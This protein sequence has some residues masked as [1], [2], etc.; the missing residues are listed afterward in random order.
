M[1]LTLKI[2]IVKD[3]SVKAMKFAPTMFVHEACAQIRE[4][5]NDSG[6]DH[7]LFQPGIEGKRPSRWLKMD[8]TLQLYDLKMNDEIDYKKKHR[9]LKVKLMDE[10]LKTLLIDD[11]LSVGE[12]IEIIGKRI[13]I[14]NHEEFSLQAEQG[15]ATSDWLNH[16]QP[17]HEQGVSDEAIVLLKKKFFV[18]D[19]NVNRDDPIQL[20]LVYVQSRDA[21]ISGSHPCTYDEAIQFGALQCQIQLGNHNT[22][23][24]KPG[25]LK[26]KE[27]MPPS[28]HKKKDAEKD[29]YKEFRKLVGMTESNSKFRYVQLCRSLKTYG[30]T[31]FQTKER[32]KGQKKPVPKLLG[33]TRDSVL[34]LDAETKEVEH[35]YPLTHL[36]RWAA[37][38]ASFTLDFGDYEDDYVSVITSDGEA[39]SQ[40]LSGYIEILMKKRKD[41]SVTV[42]EGDTDIANIESI[43]RIRGQAANTTTSS[44]L[45]GFDGAGGREGQYS[46]P[47]QSIGYRGGLGGPLSVKV[48]NIDSASAAVANLLNEMELDP[49]SVIGQK[50]ALTP[51]QWRQQ[52][53]IHAKAVAAAAG[54][55]LGNLNNPNGMDRGMV[56]Q[57]ARDIALTIDQLVHAAR[58]ASIAAGED[59]DGEMPL[60]DGAR[61]VAEAISKLL[62]ATKDLA[63][64]PD[65]EN[66]RNLV[67]QAAEQLRLMT[68]YLDG[69]CNGVITDQGT[70]RLLQESGKAIAFATQELVNNANQMATT[71]ADPIRRNQLNNAT[72]ETGKA[73]VLASATAQALAPTILDPTCRQQFDAASKSAQDS[74]NYLLA[75]AKSSNL[76]S[77]LL[78]KLKAHAKQITD[79]YAYLLQSADLA[80]PKSGDDVEFSNAAK[81]ILAASAQMLGAQGRPDVIQGATKSI[82]EAMIHLIAGAKRATLKTDDPAVRDRL[83]QCSKTVAEAARHLVEVAQF[84]AEN[85]DDKAAFAKLQD[86]SKR[87][88]MATKQLVGD[89]GKEEA[90][91]ALRTN[92]KLACAAT[93]GLITTSKQVT[94]TLPEQDAAR[95]QASI[96]RAL[97]EIGEM[98]GAIN[99]SQTKPND[100]SA[101]NQLVDQIKVSAPIAFQLVADAKATIPKVQDPVLK[102]ELTHSANVASDAIK[103]LLESIQDLSSAVGQQDF[104]DALEQV[105]ALEADMEAQSYAAQSGLIQNIP[106]QTRENAMELLNV[107][108]RALGNS[109]KQVLL[110]YKTAPDQL[111]NTCKD[112]SNSVGQVT[113]AAKAVSAT[114]QNRSVQRAVLG[115]AKQITTESANL[116]SCARAVS[117][118]P[119][120]APL[121][122]ALQ[123][124]VKAIAEALAALL[125]T[126][127]GGDPGGKDLDDAIE[128]IKND[129]KRINNPPVSLG[130]EYGTNSD[131]AISSS[132]ALLASSSQTSANARSN[133]SA[134]GPSSKTTSSTY[135]Q[136]VD[137][138]NAATGSCPNKNLA[139][140]TANILAQLGEASIKLLQASRYAA[141]RPGEGE[142]ELT[143]AQSAIDALVKQL[144]HTIQSA[145]PGQAEI[146][147]AIAIVKQCIVQ[148]NTGVISHSLRAD[149]LKPCTTAA[150]ELGE[151][152]GQVVNS[153]TQ[154]EKMGAN[155]KKAALDLLDATECAKSA[156]Y[157]STEV[158]PDSL[159]SLA[160][161]VSAASSAL[162]ESCAKKT[163]NEQDKKEAAVNAKNLALSV[164]N[165]MN[166]ARKLSSQAL[167]AGNPERSKQILLDAQNVANATT[168]LVNIAKTVASGQTAPAEQVRA[169]H[170]EVSAYIRDL[171]RSVEGLDSAQQVE[172]DL[173][174]LSPAEQALLDATRSVANSMS[175]FMAISKNISTGTKDANVH[176]SFSSAAQSVSAGVQQLLIAINGMRPEQK[177]IDESIEIIQQAVVDLD[178]ASLNAAIG[179]LE[180]TAPAGKTAQSCQEDLVEVS[181]ELAT[182]MK[183]F[184]AAPKENPANLG[185]SAKNTANLLPKIVNISKQ[186]ASLTTNPEI[187]QTQLQ[188]SKK[189]ADNMLE[190]MIAAKGGDVS[191]SKQAF[192]ASQA[193][194]D[195]LTSVKGGVM[196]SRDCDEAIQ[197]IN[198]SK[199]TLYKPAPDSKGKTYQ[200]YRDDTT[201]IAKALALGISALVNA[202]K[203]KP[204][205]IGQNSL[206]VGGIIPRLVESSRA[207]ASATND[208]VAKQKLL[209][210]TN[211]IVDS[212]ALIIAD[213][214][215]ASAD[216]KNAALQGKINDNFKSVT[217]SIANLISALKA[218]ATGDRDVDAALEAINKATSD[219]D[220]ASLFA[221]AGQIDVE[222][223]GQTPQQVQQD[224]D[225]LAK[226]LHEA[227]QQL[228]KASTIEEVGVNA[229]HIAHVNSQLANA[230]KVC[231]A[232]TA[233]PNMQQ[234]I[235]NNSR[236]VSS[237]LQA[238]VSATRA[239]QKNPTPANNTM[240]TQ[241]SKALDESIDALASLANSSTTT[242]GIRELDSIAAEIR[243][244][245]GTY[246][247]ANATSN[248]NAT[249][250]DVVTSAKSLAES[251]AYLVS[252]TN[253]APDELDSAAKGTN[254]SVRS[255]LANAKGATRLTDDAVIQQNVTESA[256]EAS[257]KILKLVQAAKSVRSDPT[258]NQAQNKLSEASAEVA[259]AIN[260]VVTAAGDLPGGE[261]AKKLFQAGENLEEVAEKELK[262]AARVIE[263]ATAALLKAKKK[264]EDARAASG[265]DEAGID[266][267]IL[268]AARAITSA[269]G[270]LVNCASAVQHE[271]VAQGKVNKGG[272]QYRRDPTWA[273]GLISAAQAVAGSV[274]TLVVSAN[275]STQG[276]A[277]E[278]TLVAAAKGVAAT[279]AR[280]VAASRAKADLNSASNSQ[281]SQAAK[282]VSNATSQLVEAAKSVGKQDEEVE[283]FDPSGM[284]FTGLKVHE[285]EQQVRIL[286]LK[287]ELEQAEKK[288]F[289]IRKHEYQDQTGPAPT[290]V[291]APTPTPAPAPKPVAKGPARPAISP[292]TG[293]PIVKQASQQRFSTSSPI[294]ASSPPSESAP[295]PAVVPSPLAPGQTMTLT[296]LQ[297]KPAGL[298]QNNL[299]I[300]LSDSE[301]QSIFKMNKADFAKLPGWRKNKE[302]QN[303]G[304]F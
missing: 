104:D 67:A 130:G 261:R 228:L 225:R 34:R 27:Y 245:L 254:A 121:E 276:K 296:E 60:F 52:L 63:A 148:L 77:A 200:E 255:L 94:P 230:A 253:N 30:I 212:T 37:S 226:E 22:N 204:D 71:I 38:P 29:I 195:I 28:Y 19:F 227:N 126:S 139:I 55:L 40:L 202:A 203:N 90:F 220:A 123:S 1:S 266:E 198:Q 282:Q 168:K 167:T 26:I 122:L 186:L 8:K 292:A 68:A 184:L 76:D 214:K 241:S 3:G 222:T 163:L 13:G 173:D 145:V 134:L 192:N 158:N 174:A 297:Q 141:S 125:A 179:L 280:L 58:A 211:G 159:S 224:I 39:I 75:T 286:K 244:Q 20:H 107:A 221:A 256:K 99:N 217:T 117:A 197:T 191:D 88:A 303:A 150:K 56:D 47:G 152:T 113:N 260:E 98:I 85:P 180:N 80:Q 210:A 133:P 108:A 246:D 61:S 293:Q 263:E 269:T 160:G 209:D 105:Q 147:E 137:T 12:I 146:G 229:K 43:G 135:T 78:E 10:T 41:T 96:D 300:Y 299:E 242:K 89:A 235:L 115:A 279:T 62:K 284:S 298:D 277:E 247:T 110:Q 155:C 285:M 275:D 59:P 86:A 288:L 171:L 136:L 238:T 213:A 45:S 189:L 132:K 205:E 138:C 46:V 114:S 83:I 218:G 93:T 11:S 243:K 91:Q 116:I 49:N 120:D 118:N 154:S 268:E 239:A 128:A 264:R 291:A 156:I 215:L 57:N 4:R 267:A 153:K 232:L 2:R 274:Q 169:A 129:I 54:K 81:Q 248:G 252:S 295:A 216:N 283:A 208:A 48:T 251:I 196:Q 258:N 51:Q 219:L 175:Q 35:E 250:E 65:D 199:E 106:G 176:Q 193:I 231:A 66:A 278:E 53:A 92:A 304:L 14:K 301:F 16:T 36:R 33:I 272:N 23:L 69:A 109:A 181:R 9:A 72:D 64:N 259:E 270:I 164:P 44:S 74:I 24:H 289:S 177:D 185:Q 103:V 206:K 127:K 223:D 140:E 82:E 157:G 236:N 187:K 294:E 101:Q 50:S 166:A 21:I 281:L 32:V 162:N 131:K 119:G 287:K 233:D 5:I 302:K 207:T 149:P 142:T 102:S 7:G 111:G 31:F 100:I 161:K 240:K 194:A 265:I 201:E 144:T 95:I 271:L 112:L 183:V 87:L 249:A 234:N 143:N 290:P 6:E 182:A 257:N 42:E 70:L 73:G 237:N 15:G 165:L 172:I 190:L 273:R 97:H 151:H 124:S 170:D 17:L 178:S 188:L 84:S 25:Y 18:D 79:A 262:E